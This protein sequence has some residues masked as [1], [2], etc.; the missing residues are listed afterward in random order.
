VSDYAD[1]LNDGQQ[2]RN[3]Q[4][5]GHIRHY[6]AEYM[7]DLKVIRTDE[8]HTFTVR[9]DQF[10]NELAKVIINRLEKNA[11]PQQAEEKP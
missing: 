3:F 2:L 8:E 10:A 11:Q 7:Q 1:G 4:E 9:K 5:Y 6:I